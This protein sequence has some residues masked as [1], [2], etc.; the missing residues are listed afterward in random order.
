MAITIEIGCND[1]QGGA[2]WPSKGY[3]LVDGQ[4]QYIGHENDGCDPAMSHTAGCP[5]RMLGGI[6]CDSW[7]R[8]VSGVKQLL[9]QLPN[10]GGIIPLTPDILKLIN[11]I[12]LKGQSLD[13]DRTKWLQFWANKAV[14]EFNDKAVIQLR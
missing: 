13:I 1:G 2:F 10:T 11:S 14:T 5:Y 6:D 3:E 4:Y 9:G 8:R 7:E 12:P